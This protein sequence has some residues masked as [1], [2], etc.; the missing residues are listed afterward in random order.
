[1]PGLGEYACRYRQDQGQEGDGL[2]GNSH[3]SY[4]LSDELV[5][6]LDAGSLTGFDALSDVPVDS[7]EE[8]FSEDAELPDE[9]FE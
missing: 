4:F 3:L 9:P 8:L 2:K 6:A 1:M 5:E 7:A